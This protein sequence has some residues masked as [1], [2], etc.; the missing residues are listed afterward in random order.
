MNRIKLERMLEMLRKNPDKFPQH[1]TRNTELEEGGPIAYIKAKVKQFQDSQKGYRQNIARHNQAIEKLRPIKQQADRDSFNSGMELGKQFP[2]SELVN[3]FYRMQGNTVAPMLDDSNSNYAPKMM[4]AK[5][6]YLKDKKANGGQ[7]LENLAPIVGV[8]PGMQPVSAAMGVIGGL[9]KPEDTTPLMPTNRQFKLGGDF[10]QYNSPSHKDGGQLIDMNG[11]PVQDNAVA[12]IEKQEN[13]YQGYVYSDKLGEGDKTYA[14]M[15]KK[16]NRQTNKNSDIDRKSKILQLARL[17]AKNEIARQPE[18]TPML[19]DGGIIPES[20]L[21]FDYTDPSLM[22]LDVNPQF[23]FTSPTDPLDVEPN[24]D[25]TDPTLMDFEVPEADLQFDMTSI[26]QPQKPIDLNKTAALLKGTALAASGVDALR[27]P[28]QERLRQPDYSAGDSYTTDMSMDFAPQ[29][30]EINRASTKAISDVS[31]QTSSI[32]QRSSRVAGILSRAGANKAQAQLGQQQANNQLKMNQ[33]QRSDRQSEVNAN[34][35]IRR[36][37]VQARNDA[38]S[39]LAGRKFFQD[40]SQVG[41]TLNQLVLNKDMVKNMNDNQR[42]QTIFGM[43]M[44]SAKYPNFKPS[45]ELMDAINNKNLTEKN[46]SEMTSLLQ[47]IK[48]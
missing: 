46:L 20:D 15:A 43:N 11:N 1:L 8:I 12:E 44:L 23:D 34:E 38:T 22:N 2:E 31:D 7:F 18:Q 42:M 29:L 13:S 27:R 26:K 16:I 39:R 47:F 14:E 35:L 10:K 17:K 37:D 5:G 9:M 40:V 45:Q 48:E 28:D 19:Q 32:G 36:D 30:A 3:D 33:A 4:L 25:F 21:M 6:G 24:F 41:T